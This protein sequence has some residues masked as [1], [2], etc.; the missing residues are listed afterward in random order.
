ML[1]FEIKSRTDNRLVIKFNC[2][3]WGAFAPGK[4]AVY[5]TVVK[6]LRCS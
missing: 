2:N 5:Y 4:P 3:A 6:E 1:R